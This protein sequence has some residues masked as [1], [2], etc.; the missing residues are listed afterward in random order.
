[1]A[2]NYPLIFPSVSKSV[3]LS[4][5]LLVCLSVFLVVDL[6]VCLSACLPGYLV[7]SVCIHACLFVRL[8]VFLSG[9]QP[10]CLS[11]CLFDLFKNSKSVCKKR[12]FYFPRHNT[13][14]NSIRTPFAW[15]YTYNAPYNH[16]AVK[17]G[18]IF[19]TKRVSIQSSILSF[20]GGHWNVI[21]RPDKPCFQC[22]WTWHMYRVFQKSST[23]A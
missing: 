14:L 12:L 4:V 23:V 21:V 1:M 18:A 8:C 13:C 7:V 15:G 3:F 22:R 10:V 11:V 19:E 5:C 17:C 2:H 6:S 20:N 16:Y 9:W